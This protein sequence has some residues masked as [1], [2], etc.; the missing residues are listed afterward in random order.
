MGISW[1]DGPPY[2]L[3]RRIINN[4]PMKYDW[5]APVSGKGHLEM[6]ML[7]TLFKVGDK[8][9]FDLLGKDVLQFDT[10]KSYNYFIDCKDNHKA[11]QALEIFL[12]GTSMELIRLYSSETTEAP[13]PLG[14]LKWTQEQQALTL[15]SVNLC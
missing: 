4:D 14:F 15:T 6:N 10:N 3:M 11:Y 9:L 8:V 2:C 5:V 7:K 13:S 12:F 1:A